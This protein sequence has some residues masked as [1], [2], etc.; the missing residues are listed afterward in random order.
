MRKLISAKLAA[1]ILLGI[2]GLLAIFHLLVLARVVPSDIVWGGQSGAS[3]TTL[4]VQ[5]AIA[6]GLT[7]FFG[8]IVAAKVGYIKVGA[9]QK[10]ITILVWILFVYSLLNIAGNLASGSSTEKL[11][12]TPVSIGVAFLVFRLALEK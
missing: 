11:V 2:Y 9:F 8:V 1:N 3:Q 12:F 4:V 10:V 7:A 6:L 5:E